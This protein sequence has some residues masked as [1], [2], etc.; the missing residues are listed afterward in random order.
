MQGSHSIKHKITHVEYSLQLLNL[1]AMNCHTELYS[2]TFCF[3]MRTVHL[4]FLSVA[5]CSFFFDNCLLL[6]Q[7]IVSINGALGSDYSDYGGYECS[8]KDL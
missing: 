4:S 3:S 8:C 6:I 1:I 5:A 2:I 7:L